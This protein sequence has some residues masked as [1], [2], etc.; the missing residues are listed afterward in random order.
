MPGWGKATSGLSLIALA[1]TVFPS[2]GLHRAGKPKLQQE[3]EYL[4]GL[5]GV[6]L[7]VNQKISLTSSRKRQEVPVP[8]PRLSPNPRR[9]QHLPQLRV[10]GDPG[11]L[12]GGYW[13]RCTGTFSLQRGPGPDCDQ[14][15]V[16]GQSPRET[17]PETAGVRPTQTRRRARREE[18]RKEGR[19]EGNGGLEKKENEGSIEEEKEG[20]MKRDRRAGKGRRACRERGRGEAAIPRQDTGRTGQGAGWR[21]SR[22]IVHSACR[23]FAAGP[24][25]R[26]AATSV[27]TQRRK[28]PPLLPLP[29]DLLWWA[30]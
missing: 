11:R 20:K 16:K 5:D 29:G 2:P 12:L 26:A 1:R 27:R 22:G 15:D 7:A 28:R 3:T 10:A 18:G 8:L 4:F 14:E 13:Q 25:P 23:A 21:S 19:K 17:E 24:A 9:C 6:R 30:H